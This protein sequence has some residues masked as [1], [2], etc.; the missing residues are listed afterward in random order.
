MSEGTGTWQKAAV[1]LVV[2]AAVAMVVGVA[3]IRESAGSPGRS[4]ESGVARVGSATGGAPEGLEPWAAEAW[5]AYVSW[6]GSN[7][8]H[9]AAEVLVA[10]A[11]NGGYSECMEAAGYPRPWQESISPPPVF[12]DGLLYSFWAGGR[13][14]GYF[15]QTVIN[16]EIGQRTE[17]AEN[18]VNAVGEEADAEMVCGEAN[19]AASDSTVEGYRDPPVVSR[20]EHEWAEALAPVLV[21]GGDPRDYDACIAETGILEGSGFDSVDEFTDQLASLMPVGTVPLGDEA[22]TPEWDA[23]LVTEQEFVDADWNCRKDVRAELADEVTE[24]VAGFEAAHGDQ[25]SQA[26]SHWDSVA[27]QAEDLGWTPDD[28]YLGAGF[29]PRPGG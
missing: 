10:Y 27:A 19:P 11:L 18:A 9:Q 8:E 1:P 26:R 3:A 14:D 7:D 4:V 5:D 2:A 15:S 25:I 16:G 29:P 21:A 28:P 24:A 13:R 23:Y 17:L 12:K 6:A 20:L 22:S